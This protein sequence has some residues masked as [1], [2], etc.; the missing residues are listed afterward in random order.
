MN[1]PAI[2]ASTA[3]TTIATP[4]PDSPFFPEAEPSVPVMFTASPARGSGVVERLYAVVVRPHGAQMQMW[5]DTNGTAVGSP[6]SAQTSQLLSHHP[7]V[8]PPSDPHFP[9]SFVVV[10]TVVTVDVVSVVEVRVVGGPVYGV[11]VVAVVRVAVDEEDVLEVE[12]VVPSPATHQDLTPSSTTY[13]VAPYRMGGSVVSNGP[14]ATSSSQYPYISMLP[15]PS[16]IIHLWSHL[17]V[18]HG[19]HHTDMSPK[20]PSPPGRLNAGLPSN[21]PT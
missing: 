19:A 5:S 13:P 21:K 18:S 8:C 7:C 10:V 3:I 15:M 16:L 6:L 9:T 17:V 11:V 2:S 14:F 4:A 12:V 20:S 1:G